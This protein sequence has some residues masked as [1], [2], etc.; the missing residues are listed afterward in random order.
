[1]QPL[2]SSAFRST[3]SKIYALKDDEKGHNINQEI[4]LY[5]K[6]LMEE[7]PQRC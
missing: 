4:H 6:N 1:M 7:V 3:A 5:P 2:F